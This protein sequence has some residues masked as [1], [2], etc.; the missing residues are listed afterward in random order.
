MAFFAQAR[1]IFFCVF[2]ANKPASHPYIPPCPATI[3]ARS[4]LRSVPPKHIPR[5]Q[6]YAA[7]RACHVI[8]NVYLF[9]ALFFLA[10]FNAIVLLPCPFTLAPLA[11]PLQ[12]FLNFT[13]ALFPISILHRK[14]RLAAACFPYAPE[15]PFKPVYRIAFC[16]ILQPLPNAAFPICSPCHAPFHFLLQ[17]MPVLPFSLSKQAKH[18]ICPIIFR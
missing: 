10:R 4:S 17:T 7:V 12:I 18:P 2:L 8:A 13:R 11:M 9:I 1:Q 14:C 16:H 15:S 3:F 6:V 5:K